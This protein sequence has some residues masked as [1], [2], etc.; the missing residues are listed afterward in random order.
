MIK[1]VTVSCFSL[2]FSSDHREL[3]KGHL[4]LLPAF[5]WGSASE[6]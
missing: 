5:E 6:N 1:A 4:R 3:I 2:F